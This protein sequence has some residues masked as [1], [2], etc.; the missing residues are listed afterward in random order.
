[1]YNVLT[2]AV[3]FQVILEA[4]ENDNRSR[5]KKRKSVQRQVYLLYNYASY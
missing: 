2:T 4:G 5:L 3:A 1:M